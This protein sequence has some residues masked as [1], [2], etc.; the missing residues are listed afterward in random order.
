MEKRNFEKSF[1]NGQNMGN[2]RLFQYSSLPCPG[3]WCE[4]KKILWKNLRFYMSIHDMKFRSKIRVFRGRESPRRHDSGKRTAPLICL[5]RT[6]TLCR[7]IVKCPQWSRHFT[8]RSYET[9]SLRHFI[10]KILGGHA[11]ISCV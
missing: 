8:K 11:A 9:K 1:K 5:S 10:T 7:Y 4:Q 2:S 6:I 3:R